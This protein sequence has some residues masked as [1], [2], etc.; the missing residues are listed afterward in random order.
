MSDKV[1]DKMGQYLKQKDIMLKDLDLSRNHI[2]D[3]GL[4][5]LSLALKENTSIKFLN[6]GSNKIKEETMA[7]MV[8]LLSNNTTLEELSLGSNLI[9]NEGI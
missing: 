9:N 2:S 8:E 4:K 7:D 1:I 3:V 6:L 5:T